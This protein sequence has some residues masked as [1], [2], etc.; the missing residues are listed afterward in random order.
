MIPFVILAAFQGIVI[1][2]D[3]IFFHHKRGLPK[4]ERIGHPL[5]TATVITCLLFLALA[6]KNPTTTFIYYGLAIFSC[7]FITKDE[8]VHRKFCTAEEMWLHAVLFIIHPLLL[9]SAAEIWTTHQEM[10]LMTSLG[11]IGFFV[12][13]VTY[14]NFIEYR[15]QEHRSLTPYQQDEETFH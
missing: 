10:L 13:Q 7:V 15:L 5:D 1:L 3:E 14:W 2:V 6:P 8:W 9:F 12:Y 4:W 11:V